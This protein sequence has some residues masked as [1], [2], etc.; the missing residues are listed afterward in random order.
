MKNIKSFLIVCMLVIANTINIFANDS[1]IF[2]DKAEKTYIGT[3]EATP[4]IAN[5]KF[6]DLPTK[7][8]ANEAIIKAGA[9]N[10]VK[11][12]DRKY[13][14]NDKVSN[15][16]ALAFIVR[17]MGLEKEAQNLAKGLK[18]QAESTSPL[19]LWSLGY[20]TVAKNN[21]LINNKQYSQAMTKDQSTLPNDAFKRDAY[22]TREQT[23][24]WL[25]QGINAIKETP[26]VSNNQQSIYNYS[27]WKS[28]DVDMIENVEIAL[29]N[30][31]IK[32]NDK[33]MLNPKGSLTR[34]EMAQ[35]LS[36]L[37]DIYNEI[38][39]LVEKYGTIGGIKDT[40][41]T[42]T[43]Q[44]M[45]KRDIYVRTKDGKVDIVTYTMENSHKHNDIKN[46][47]VVFLNGKVASLSN[48]REG[49]EIS[50][51]VD[52]INNKIYFASVKNSAINQKE[53]N[54]KLKKV[55][56]SKNNIQIM[57]NS[58]KMFV[59]STLQG[60]MGQ[61]NNGKYIYIGEKKVYEKKVPIGSKINIILQN[62]IV[63]KIN[64]VGE[65]NLQQELRGVVVDNNPEFGYITVLD[66]DAKEVTKNY[67]SDDIV[68]EKQPYYDDRDDIGYLD[69][70]FPSFE[71]DPRDTTIDKIEAGDIVF[72]RSQKDDPTYI[73]KISASPN[74]IM[75]YGKVQQIINDIDKIN[76]TIKLEDGQ[77][78]T[79]SFANNIFTSK[80]GKPIDVSAITSGDF[81]KI[82]VNEAI[83]SPGEVIESVKEIVVEESGHLISNILKGEIGKIDPIQKTISLQHSYKI[84]KNGWQ[85]YEQ[86]RTINLK[87]NDTEYYYNGERVSLGFVEAK[88]KRANGTAYVAIEDNFS[89][90]VA[91]KITF[92]ASRDEMLEP[93]VVVTTNG[94]DTFALANSGMITADEGTI[95][96]KNGKL[97]SPQNIN[98]NDY[99]VVS[100]N[101][102]GKASI[103]DIYDVPVVDTI[104]IARVRIK[105]IEDNKYFIAKSMSMLNG[106]EWQYSPIERK[107][108]IDGQTVYITKDGI[109]NINQFIGYTDETSIDKAFTVVFNG[110]MATHIIESAFPTKV[111]FGT[112]YEAKEGIKLKDGKYL[113][114]NNVLKDVS[115]KNST[116]NLE[117]GKNT[118]VIKNNKISSLDKIQKDDKLRVLTE[119]LP[120]EIESG[121]KINAVIIFVEN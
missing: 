26:I 108:N 118:I 98:V 75:R 97:V 70:I 114:E 52:D 19:P 2:V 94:I 18:E 41:I 53:V 25:I 4:L 96:R 24:N 82:L 47:A 73:D 92:R 103:V 120:K 102:Q 109:K 31:I 32:G 63:H 90:D 89:G 71:Y 10:M 104:S 33:K 110:D 100:L 37:G 84:G 7:Y 65:D 78:S 101:G 67:F 112:V 1:K 107:F 14:P 15:Q 39:G 64:Y 5:L 88:L 91:R 51:L 54:G 45:I 12:Y 50:Y 59:Y 72:I 49:M 3:S 46:D 121:M 106:N 36:N 40:Q 115:L 86:I 13:R 43:G 85:D 93:N 119:D 9:L 87:N 35:I 61:D 28:T 57:N 68:V 76:M 66:N 74:Y 111:A 17:V 99:A 44:A 95:I 69:E 8:W 42:K 117:T 27:D 81:V 83:L 79:Y 11:G 48:L 23:I 77:I 58:R 113:D 60:L 105:K 20:L 6:T 62:N 80:A 55:D 22:A 56:F 34:A 30:S 29:D 38:V 116:I 16:E 21:K